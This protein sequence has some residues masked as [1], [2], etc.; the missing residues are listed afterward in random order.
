MGTSIIYDGTGQESCR[1]GDKAVVSS[2]I[3]QLPPDTSGIDV[4]VPLSSGSGCRGSKLR[5][6]IQLVEQYH[7]SQNGRSS[8]CFGP[9]APD[10]CTTEMSQEIKALGNGMG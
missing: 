10:M 9:H 8:A 4:T 3:N 2:M 5:D 6:N 7:E 1:T